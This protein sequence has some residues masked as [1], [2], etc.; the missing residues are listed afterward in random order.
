MIISFAKYIQLKSTFSSSTIVF[1]QLTEC[2]NNRPINYIRKSYLHYFFYSLL[3]INCPLI[4]NS[5][6]FFIIIVINVYAC[7]TAD[8]IYVSWGLTFMLHTCVCVFISCEL[9]F[10]LTTSHLILPALKQNALMWWEPLHAACVSSLFSWNVCARK[11]H[12]CERTSMESKTRD[13]LHWTRWE[14]SREL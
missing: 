10:N 14:F 12:I 8:K 11:K 4:F 1:T 7:C 5:H 13:S 2:F 9:A 3:P 6:S